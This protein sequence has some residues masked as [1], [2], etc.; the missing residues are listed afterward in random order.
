MQSLD[1]NV[2][3]Y[4]IIHPIENGAYRAW[5]EILRK[6]IGKSGSGDE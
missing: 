2:R 4:E 6:L 1:I 3:A 5:G